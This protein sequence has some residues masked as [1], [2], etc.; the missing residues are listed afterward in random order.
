MDEGKGSVAWDKMF[1]QGSK[2]QK[3]KAIKYETIIIILLHIMVIFMFI[4]MIHYHPL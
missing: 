3:Q 4:N 1:R 2:M